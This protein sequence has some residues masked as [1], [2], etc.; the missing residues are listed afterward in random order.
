VIGLTK[1]QIAESDRK[2]LA[3]EGADRGITFG[4]VTV[5]QVVE[6]ILSRL[7]HTIEQAIGRD[8]DAYARFASAR[9]KS[10]EP[11][12]RE[13]SQFPLRRWP[14]AKRGGTSIKSLPKKSGRFWR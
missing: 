10:K 7:R 12:D 14:R 2:S 13:F 9:I 6:A 4:A 5:S 3:A 8:L 11:P 1:E